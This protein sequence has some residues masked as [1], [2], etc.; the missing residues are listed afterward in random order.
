M[1]CKI[2]GP[3]LSGFTIEFEVNNLHIN[4]QD[5]F[6]SAVKNA[7]V[8]INCNGIQINGKTD[9]RG[10][11]LGLVVP[12]V[13][14]DL[15]I[16]KGC[17]FTYNQKFVLLDRTDINDPSKNL[18][19]RIQDASNNSID[20]ADVSI[21]SEIHSISG[22]SDASGFI[23]GESKNEFLNTITVS[24]TGYQTSVQQ[25]SPFVKVQCQETGFSVASVVVL[26]V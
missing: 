24:K 18:L 2:E 16:T 10:C 13:V 9:N 14:C 22:Q 15:T 12:G 26:N 17:L 25:I 7:S 6:G 8:S 3:F 19:L 21:T 5:I 1:G 11:Y 23:Y 4:V 20:G